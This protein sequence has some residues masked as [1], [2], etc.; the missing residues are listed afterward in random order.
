MFE[1]SAHMTKKDGV[2]KTFK[3]HMLLRCLNKFLKLRQKEQ[4]KEKPYKQL[5]NTK[6]IVRWCNVS[7][8]S[9]AHNV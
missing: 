9:N 4:Q 2:A 3:S 1:L 8:N 6:L 7:V 5:N